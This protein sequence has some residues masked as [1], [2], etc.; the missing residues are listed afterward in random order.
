MKIESLG[1]AASGVVAV[2]LLLGACDGSTAAADAQVAVDIAVPGDAGDVRGDAGPDAAPEPEGIPCE[3]AACF[4][5]AERPLHEHDF[6]DQPFLRA[7]PG[8]LVI[9]ELESAAHDGHAN[10][11]GA[12]SGVDRIPYVIQG[13]DHQLSFCSADDGTEEMGLIAHDFALIDDQTGAEILTHVH[14]E[15]C[16]EV[17]LEPGLYTLVIR[18][19]GESDHTTYFLQAAPEA[20]EDGTGTA[21]ILAHGGF[22][23]GCNFTGMAPQSNLT[24]SNV[25]LG[26]ANLSGTRLENIRFQ[27]GDF[28]NAV[29]DNAEL[30]DVTFDSATLT[31]TSFAGIVGNSLYFVN[32]TASGITL[33]GN[34]DQPMYGRVFLH[35][36]G[37]TFENVALSTSQGMFFGGGVAIKSVSFPN[38]AHLRTVHP[39]VYEEHLS[40]P[41]LT[42]DSAQFHALFTAPRVD[43][44]AG[45]FPVC[46][47][48]VSGWGACDTVSFGGPGTQAPFT[49]ESLTSPLPDDF[50]NCGEWVGEVRGTQEFGTAGAQ[51]G[52]TIFSPAASP[53]MQFDLGDRYVLEGIR[54]V[55]GGVCDHGVGQGT[56]LGMSGVRHFQVAVSDTGTADTDFT[57]VAT[58]EMSQNAYP[59]KWEALRTHIALP[60]GVTGRYVRLVIGDWW[61]V[62]PSLSQFEVWTHGAALAAG[63]LPTRDLAEQMAE[64]TDNQALRFGDMS[65]DTVELESANF[66]LTVMQKSRAR[67]NAIHLTEESRKGSILMQSGGF[68][69]AGF[70]FQKIDSPLDSLN[71][72]V[73]IQYPTGVHA[74]KQ[75]N[76]GFFTQAIGTEKWRKLRIQDKRNDSFTVRV[77]PCPDASDPTICPS[78]T[79]ELP[80]YILERQTGTVVSG[81]NNINLAKA[82]LQDANLSGVPITNVRFG[83]TADRSAAEPPKTIAR[84]DLSYTGIDLSGL[85]FS[86]RFLDALTQQQS[87]P[88]L[89]DDAAVDRQRCKMG[90]LN[91]QSDASPLVSFEGSNLTGCDLSGANFARSMLRNAKLHHVTYVGDP[92]DFRGVVAIRTAFDGAKLAS[93]SFAPARAT[94]GGSHLNYASLSSADLSNADLSRAT[95]DFAQLYGTNL[96]GAILTNAS[97]DDSH[98]V[99]AI[100]TDVFGPGASFNDANLVDVNFTNA[101]FNGVV[102]GLTSNCAEFKRTWLCGATLGP[103]MKLNCADLNEAVMPGL[104]DPEAEPVTYTPAGSSES[105]TCNKV[106]GGAPL[107]DGDTNC[108]SGLTGPC[109]G[110]YWEYTPPTDTA[111]APVC[112]VDTSS[113][114]FI[115]NGAPPKKNKGEACT[116]ACDC[117][118]NGAGCSGGTCNGGPLP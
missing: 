11:S 88:D 26:G 9:V 69:A 42:A 75:D 63:A 33:S 49:T 107:T 31:G 89:V 68:G 56:V 77:D 95:L 20:K 15:P 110:G 109:S 78:F 96:H 105:L 58:G 14:G 118:D 106:Q 57:V 97:F 50:S 112:K 13:E 55:N 8:Q 28:T 17:T 12:A 44:A 39:H 1:F 74:P 85:D 21:A 32:S 90:G 30:L 64:R 46:R 92:P 18:H 40:G 93:V 71:Y 3:S 16:A 27:G 59:A 115:L 47:T 81:L 70:A 73:V 35:V 108:P 60:P 94:G 43:R 82:R 76:S 111:A 29:F 83:P 65:M 51:P 25:H 116:T 117:Y 79:G 48:S 10:D 34:L 62:A 45:T 104:A 91:V 36:W 114:D 103:T 37:G 67:Y 38:R 72:D 41:T 66:D 19:D 7:V 86:G 98:C 6:I 54:L 100:F 84:A 102:E 101:N 113:L 4:T 61:G 80:Y 2:G 52:Q 24:W 5:L 23:S 22:C 53:E 99:A 87:N